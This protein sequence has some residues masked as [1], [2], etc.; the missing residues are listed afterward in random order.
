MTIFYPT[1]V[2]DDTAITTRIKHPLCLSNILKDF[3]IDNM[4][5]TEL[6][7]AVKFIILLLIPKIFYAS[8]ACN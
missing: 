8:W 3:K 4:E 6:K 2:L 1:Q 7:R 5:K